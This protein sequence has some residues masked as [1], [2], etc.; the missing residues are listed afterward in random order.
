[1]VVGLTGTPGTG[2]DTVAEAM[3]DGG[4]N[5]LDLTQ[6]ARSAGCVVGRDERRGTDEVDEGLLRDAVDA[7]VSTGPTG[8]R[9]LLVGHM[10]HL[11]PCDRIVV[12]RCSP[13]VLRGRLEARDWPEAKVMENLEAEAVGVILVESMEV[14]PPVPV[15][16]VDTTSETPGETADRVMGV[17]DG[18]LT[19]MEAGWVDWSEEVMGW[20]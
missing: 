15:F 7:H 8:D 20:Y 17:L 9:V 3:A 2:K 14:E 12:L 19:G 18:D 16:E 4:W 10:A 5:I 11:M 13:S 6:L 1:M